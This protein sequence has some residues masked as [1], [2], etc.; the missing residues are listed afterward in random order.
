M[1]IIN[2]CY[3]SILL[4]FAV[5]DLLMLHS[6]FLEC[7]INFKF[8]LFKSNTHLFM[9]SFIHAYSLSLQIKSKVL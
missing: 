4:K 8:Q 2:V 3:D 1:Y 7:G 9:F 6:L 5:K